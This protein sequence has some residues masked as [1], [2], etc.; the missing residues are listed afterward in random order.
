M[1][2]CSLASRSYIGRYV[3]IYQHW[4]VHTALSSYKSTVNSQRSKCVA[5]ISTHVSMHCLSIYLIC[6][7]RKIRDIMPRSPDKKMFATHLVCIYAGFSLLYFWIACVVR[8]F[9]WR[10]TCVARPLLQRIVVATHASLNQGGRETI[11]I[12]HNTPYMRKECKDP[13][14]TFLLFFFFFLNKSSR[15]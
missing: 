5:R 7:C 4:T 13:E 2:V 9:T 15:F 10:L 12:A 1:P 6:T 8:A 11:Q 3:Y 14:A